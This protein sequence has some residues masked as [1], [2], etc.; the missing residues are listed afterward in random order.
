VTTCHIASSLRLFVPNSLQA[1]RHFFSEG[2]A[3]EVC[4]RPRLPFARLGS[5]LNYSRTAAAAPFLRSLAPSNSL[6]SCQPVQV[7]TIIFVLFRCLCFALLTF[8]SGPTSPQWLI[9]YRNPV[10]EPSIRFMTSNSRVC[11][12]ASHNVFTPPRRDSCFRPRSLWE[13]CLSSL[14]SVN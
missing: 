6:I 3:F 9:T 11:P 13:E 7:Y 8:W 12:R 5:R 1:Y 4:Y 14:E 10:E 2:W